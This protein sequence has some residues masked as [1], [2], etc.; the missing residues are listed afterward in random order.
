MK[1]IRN[2]LSLLI[3]IFTY[4]CQVTETTN[5]S[6]STTSNSTD[7]AIIT[8]ITT[9]QVLTDVLTENTT[10]YLPTTSITT[11]SS[12]ITTTEDDIFTSTTT[13]TTITQS[14]GLE[15]EELSTIEAVKQLNN[16]EVV[17]TKGIVTKIVTD[18]LLFIEDVDANISLYGYIKGVNVGDEIIVKGIKDNYHGLQQIIDFTVEVVSTNNSTKSAIDLDI[19]LT[20]EELLGFQGYRFNGNGFI[21]HS[22][23]QDMYGNLTFVLENMQNNRYYNCRFDYRLPNAS[24]LSNYIKSLEDQMVEF[25]NLILGYDNEPLFYFTNQN[26][27]IL[28]E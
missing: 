7:L 8:T 9:E 28:E 24:D 23:E 26:E 12:Q 14:T 16:G 19:D 10:T 6:F 13:M 4:G 22:I 5:N 20:D 3:L 21:L 18:K 17:Y 27:I 2:L 11:E 15:Q 1:T 25:N